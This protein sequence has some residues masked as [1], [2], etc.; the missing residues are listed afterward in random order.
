[1][2]LLVSA[3][4][5]QCKW[6]CSAELTVGRKREHEIICGNATTGGLIRYTLKLQILQTVLLNR[7]KTQGSPPT[8]FL[9]VPASLHDQAS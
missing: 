7:Y 6:K 9:H 2:G 8:P 1:M 4:P 3:L 5:V